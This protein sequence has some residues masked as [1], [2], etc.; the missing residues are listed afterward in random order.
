M[1]VLTFLKGITK[2]ASVC[3]LQPCF[4]I[5]IIP[6]NGS[7]ILHCVTVP[8]ILFLIPSWWTFKSLWELRVREVTG[9]SQCM[10][11][12]TGTR[13]HVLGEGQMNFSIVG[14]PG[15]LM[16]V[17]VW[18]VLLLYIQVNQHFLHLISSFSPRIS[19]SVVLTKDTVFLISSRSSICFFY[20]FNIYA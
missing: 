12:T 16:K 14:C 5:Y 4:E 8:H 17:L 15:S 11:W 19:Y 13:I 1:C 20:I 10:F 18:V 2:F 9:L 6:L 3:F 7:S